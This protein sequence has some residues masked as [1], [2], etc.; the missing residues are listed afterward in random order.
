MNCIGR[1]R[2]VGISPMGS[3]KDGLRREAGR[4][5]SRVSRS[6]AKLLL[7]SSVS[8]FFVVSALFAT[9]LYDA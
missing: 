7:Y 9:C 2:Q 5:Y 3:Q 1:A 4:P 8:H 6:R